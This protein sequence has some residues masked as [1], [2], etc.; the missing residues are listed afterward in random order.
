MIFSQIILTVENSCCP[1]VYTGNDAKLRKTDFTKTIRAK[2]KQDA[3]RYFHD[4]EES[5]DL[6]MKKYLENKVNPIHFVVKPVNKS[7][8]NVIHK[9]I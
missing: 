3:P 8:K 9:F 7:H 4:T 6:K 1:C 5:Y 2:C